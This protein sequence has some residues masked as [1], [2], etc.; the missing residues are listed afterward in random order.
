M[1]LLYLASQRIP[2]EK[3]YGIQ[4]VSMCRALS[5]FCSV[6]LILPR[7]GQG[8]LDLFQYYKVTPNFLVRY[9]TP[10]DFYLPGALDRLA[11]WL[12]QLISA[13]VLVRTALRSDYNFIY[14]R[15]ELVIWLLSFSR[16][17]SIF[18]IHRF[19][20]AKIFIYRRLIKKNTP[21]VAISQG[22]KDDLVNFGFSEDL[23][24]VA[25]DGV[26]LD[27]FML[28]ETKIDIK[29]SR[30]DLN[31][32]LDRKI[33]MYIGKFEKGKG[34]DLVLR[35]ARSLS[36]KRPDIKFVMVGGDED[37]PEYKKVW[38][39]VIFLGPQPYSDLPTNQKLG[40]VLVIPNSGKNI[41]SARYTSPLKLFAHMASNR[42][43]VASDVPALKEIVDETMV[44]FFKSDD[45]GSFSEAVIK[46]IDTPNYADRIKRTAL[47][48][49]KQYSWANRAEKIIK[50]IQ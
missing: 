8:K 28:N 9:V 42:P 43:I 21:I 7:R 36:Q 3:A 31:I 10:P 41:V 46:V 39:E 12:K 37:L 44:A 34:H 14:T 11:F 38:P 47:E 24:L 32:P 1:K 48:E 49:V 5:K 6:Q 40:D 50:F 29:K 35:S 20:T 26:E 15:D 19:S 2:T 17:K 13:F 33:V 27:K 18:E 4:I 23:I 16:A 45:P 25:H 22:I 30:A